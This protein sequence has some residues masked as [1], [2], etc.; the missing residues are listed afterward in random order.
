MNDTIAEALES[1]PAVWMH[2]YTY[3]AHPVG[4]AVALRTLRI[5]DE[6]DFPGQAAEKGAALLARL[7][8]AL[9]DHPHVGEVRGQ[10]LMCG[11]ELVQDKAT[12]A[13]FPPQEKIGTRVQAEA[14]ARGLF[15]RVRGDVFLLAPPIIT[16]HAQLERA[17]EIL[18]A[19]VRAVLG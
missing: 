8:S 16:T 15:S 4:C 19:S 14:L 18:A 10:G 17:V 7:R 1:D 12:K 2:A 3:S 6:E 11:V 9:A 5:I 13:E